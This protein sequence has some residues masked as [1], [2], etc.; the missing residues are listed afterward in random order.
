MYLSATRRTLSLPNLNPI[1]PLATIPK[2]K[3]VPH[4]R[5]LHIPTTQPW[6]EERLPFYRPEEF[7]PVHIGEILH[8]KYRV[9]GKLGYGSDSTVWLCHDQ[10]EQRY[11]AI[12]IQTTTH[13]AQSLTGE[14]RVYDHLS[15]L[16]STHIGGVY[17]RGL[18]E[19]FDVSGP[20]GVHRCLVHPPM[21]MSLHEL[22]RMSSSSWGLSD[23][24]LKQTLGCV[25]QALDFLHSV[26]G[27][28]HSDI[29]ASNIMLSID[30]DT[31]LA[32][33]EKA[34]CESPSPRKVVNQH[35]TTYVSRKL[36]FP[37]DGLWGQ[38]VLCDLGHARIG[39]SHR[40]LI[41]PD[42]YRAPEVLFDM[43]W[44]PSV[45]IWNLG[46]MVWDVFEDKHL[47]HALDEDG[48]YSPSHHVA[49]M[50][51]C[52]GLPLLSFVKR[53]QDTRHVFTD[54]GKWLGAGGV[55]IPTASL[56][57]SEESLCGDDINQRLFLQF[58]RSMLRWVPEE[59]KTAKELLEDPWLDS[60]V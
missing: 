24:I 30:D 55:T 58:I 39:L 33:F 7:Y 50:V 31:M 13:S 49:E 54:D 42:T 34:E 14:L 40:G 18:Y 6:E 3:R 56:E 41:Q 60:S 26:A 35:R 1:I 47:F 59:R 57:A 46:V 12:K 52:L 21:H 8:S 29:K 27:V 53:S 36:R 17:I 37:K 4:T 32:D 23:G 44:G 45:D 48:D 28:V 43:E 38:P 16:R 9:V 5:T 25:L 11:T 51:A 19:T 2:C 22:R 10:S 15:K 20:D